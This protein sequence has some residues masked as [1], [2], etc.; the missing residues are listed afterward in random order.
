[1]D[2]FERMHATEVR[3]LTRIDALEERLRQTERHLLAIGRCGCGG[4]APVYCTRTGTHARVR[5][6]K[7]L[8]CGDKWKEVVEILQD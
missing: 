2:A 8:S 7:C 4:I 5:Y 6:R 3:L 1:M